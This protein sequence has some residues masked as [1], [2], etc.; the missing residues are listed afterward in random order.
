[1][2][3]RVSGTPIV[4]VGKFEKLDGVGAPMTVPA[5]KRKVKK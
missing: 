5:A 4:P 2:K 3:K 1:M